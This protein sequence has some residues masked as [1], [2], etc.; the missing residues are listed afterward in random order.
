VKVVQLHLSI[1]FRKI[2]IKQNTQ[3][4][5][6]VRIKKTGQRSWFMYRRAAQQ[7]LSAKPEA[8]VRLGSD[9]PQVSIY[10]HGSTLKTFKMA[11]QHFNSCYDGKKA[12]K[13]KGR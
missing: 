3:L 7:E 13:S 10:G 4:K 8:P 1:L 11:E 6:D 2:S 9:R 5:N 12:G